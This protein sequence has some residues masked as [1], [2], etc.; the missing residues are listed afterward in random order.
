MASEKNQ[1]QSNENQPISSADDSPTTVDIL[2]EEILHCFLRRVMGY[3]PRG[4]AF[5]PA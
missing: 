2:S 4:R 5:L 3:I 1:G